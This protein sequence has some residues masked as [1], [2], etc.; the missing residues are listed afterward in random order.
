M[1]RVTVVENRHDVLLYRSFIGSRPVNRNQYIGV[2]QLSG[3]PFLFPIF[4]L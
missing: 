4:F 3:M 2:Y 1:C